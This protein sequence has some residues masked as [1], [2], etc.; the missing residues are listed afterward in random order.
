MFLPPDNGFL[1]RKFRGPKWS[2]PTALQV[3]YLLVYEGL[4]LGM[5]P[6]GWE[7]VYNF[8]QSFAT[9]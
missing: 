3:L 6:L 7:P 4:V 1:V 8:L 9:P 2:Y 5:A